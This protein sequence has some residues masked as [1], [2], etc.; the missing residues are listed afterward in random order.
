MAHMVLGGKTP[1]DSAP[2]SWKGVSRRS[3][4]KGAAAAG[5]A[6][7]AISL[8]GCGDQAT[9]PTP[10]DS[11]PASW[12][13]VSRRS[14]VKGAAAAGASNTAISLTGCGDKAT[15]PTVSEEPQVITDDSK[16][17]NV[18]EDF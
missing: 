12:K 6:I 11:A 2:A 15:G 5:A 17:Y 18:I 9:G 13:G 10:V 4:V 14:L 8:T 16:I 3:L 1:V 7:T